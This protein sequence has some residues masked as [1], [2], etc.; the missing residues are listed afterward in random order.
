[1]FGQP[2]QEHLPDGWCWDPITPQHHAPLDSGQGLS[3]SEVD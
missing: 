2:W 3:Y 1:M